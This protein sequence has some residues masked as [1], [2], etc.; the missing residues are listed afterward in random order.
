MSDR[1]DHDA[2]ER[3]ARA[4]DGQPAFASAVQAPL[5][6]RDQAPTPD[7]A[8]DA[9]DRDRRTA[10]AVALATI[11]GAVIAAGGIEW[12]GWQIVYRLGDP[13]AVPAPG[14]LGVPGIPWAL[15][16]VRNAALALGVGLGSTP[17][18]LLMPWARRRPWRAAAAAFAL[19]TASVL[20]VLAM[21]TRWAP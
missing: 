21:L 4:A 6:V 12:A 19:G 14:I 13:S 5:T 8:T 3:T 18:T 20:A 10:R 1:R 9:P 7:P 17:L 2:R 11:V 16:T 15:G